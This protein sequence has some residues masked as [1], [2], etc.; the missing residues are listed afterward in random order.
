MSLEK[1]PMREKPK[2]TRKAVVDPIVL[3]SSAREKAPTVEYI[4]ERD[5]DLDELVAA[6]RK[7]VKGVFIPRD[8]DES[9][10]EVNDWIPM[11]KDITD[12]IG[13]R[14]L[15]CGLITMAYGKKDCL[16][17]ETPISYHVVGKDGS[18]QNTKGGTLKR[19]YERFNGIERGGIHR[20]RRETSESDFYVLS[21]NQDGVLFR[22]RVTDVIAK[23]ERECITMTT[24][25][26]MA[27]TMTKDHE[28]FS[29][30]RY[31]RVFE[32]KAGDTVG[33]HLKTPLTNGHSPAYRPEIMVKYH[34]TAREKTVNGVTY[35][36][37]YEYR[38]VV[39]AHMNGMD[40][41]SY[42]AA[43]NELG[44]DEIDKFKTIPEGM[45]VHH[46]NEDPT[47][48]RLDNL[49][50]VSESEH[51]SEHAS[52]AL[53]KYVVTEEEIVS[54]ESAGAREVYD[55]VCADPYRNFVANGIVVHNCGK[56]TFATEALVNT[57]RE[58]GI[59][60]LLDTENKYNLKR[61]AK[62]GLDVKK[63]FI[64]Q[65]VTIEDAF[66][67]F[68]TIINLIKSAKERAVTKEFEHK[69]KTA[70]IGDVFKEEDFEALPP[71]LQKNFISRAKYADR[72]V[73]CVW[74][75]L[76]ATPSEWEMDDT[77]TDFAMAAAKVIKGRL[78]K[79]VRYIRDSKVAFVIINQ[80]YANT[81]SFGKKTTP[82]GGSGP[83]YHSAIILEFVQVG[84][85]RPSGGKSGEDFCGI[86]SQIEC[87]KNHLSQPFKRG[88]V[89]IDWKGFVTGDRS[90]EYAPE[91]WESGKDEP[92][93]ELPEKKKTRASSKPE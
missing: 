19:L 89:Q 90:P 28:V 41:D 68:V 29:R 10:L 88:E 37:L 84:R 32:L 58:G 83:E 13:T 47:D 27:L 23:G 4:G 51:K 57:Q 25:S 60:I 45:F 8:E 80:V 63:L 65:A 70:K 6:A 67:K 59:A 52:G 85:I 54:I 87:V 36:R 3:A 76:G 82:Y 48:N 74:D 24:K 39:E 66:D 93:A 31:V 21:S 72:K 64:I 12:V 7:Y 55:I 43:L 26:G 35:H 53:G 75:S 16:D 42:R 46:I 61:A 34:P 92:I 77:K 91:R 20:Q 86:R 9:L 79:V 33:V 18:T 62:M 69:G 49:M 1:S 15:P 14:G 78:R 11:P 50:L 38:A 22:N 30:G 40:F 44:H 17:G 56:T 2:F 71:K 81:N 73:C 5:L